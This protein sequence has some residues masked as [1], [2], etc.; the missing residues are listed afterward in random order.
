MQSETSTSAENSQ[1]NAEA[2][3]DDNMRCLFKV[4]VVK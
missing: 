4:T 3:L 1:F 2:C